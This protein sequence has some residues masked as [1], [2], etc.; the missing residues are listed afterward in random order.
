MTIPN[1]TILRKAIAI[2]A[3]LEQLEHRLEELLTKELKGSSQDLVR[4]ETL[5]S[6]KKI[7]KSWNAPFEETSFS[8]A[9]ETLPEVKKEHE[10]EAV[11]HEV[12]HEFTTDH[13]VV[14]ALPSSEPH[15]ETLLLV[16]D[17]GD[18][19][20]AIL[21]TQENQVSHSQAP[22]EEGAHFSHGWDN[23]SHEG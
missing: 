13:E 4:K 21:P 22:S 19:E 12:A 23:P 15:Q 6:S 11:A 18:E 20:L 2:K 5:K 7:Q 16:N 14:E 10:E 17:D 3:E 8:L 9:E 1:P